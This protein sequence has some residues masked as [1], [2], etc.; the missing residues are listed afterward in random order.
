M[1]LVAENATDGHRAEYLAVVEDLLRDSR[2]NVRRSR[3]RLTL[4]FSRDDVFFMMIEE[5]PTIF[6]LIAF[7]RALWGRRTGGLLFRPNECLAPTMLRLRLKQAALRLFKL[8]PRIAVV[9]I[10]PFSL[11]PRFQTI[12]RYGIYDLQLWDLPASSLAAPVTEQ[13]A[14]VGDAIKA[15]AKGRKVLAALGAQNIEKGFAFFCD[16]WSA[17]E[18]AKL[19]EEFLFVSGGAIAPSCRTSA[20]DFVRAGGVLVDRP[21]LDDELRALYACADTVWCCYAPHYNQASG[22]FG[23]AVQLGKPT[24]AR[25]GSYVAA[26]GREVGHAVI[27]LDWADVRGA[28]ALL[29]EQTSASPDRGRAGLSVADMKAFS[30]DRLG[31]AMGV[32]LPRS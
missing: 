19:R 17:P 13:A 14:A 5:A 10:L 26:L 3:A 1:I 8:F 24:T 18:N 2:T 15:A 25:S 4:V 9:T 16:T 7:L 27:L 6:F 29:L 30:L 28:A 32:R 22:I 31:E 12:A 11:N 20:D 23:R 21:L